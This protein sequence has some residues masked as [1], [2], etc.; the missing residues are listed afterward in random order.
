MHALPGEVLIVLPT[1]NEAKNLGRLV[2]ELRRLQPEADLLVIDDGSPDGTGRVADELAADHP[3]LQVVHR[4]GKLGLGSAHVLGMDRAVEGNYRVLVTMDC[5]FTHRPEDVEKLLARLRAGGVDL[6]IG[7]RYAHRAGI[8]SWPLWRKAITR[9]A[10]LLT[11][12]LLD[13]RF[14]ATNAFRAFDAGALRRV[15]Y[16]DVRGDGYS[17]MFEMVYAC[18]TSGLRIEEVPV[19]MPIRQAGQ[20]KI[21]RKEIVKAVV[22]LGRLAYARNAG[23]SRQG[24]AR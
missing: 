8:E 16:R 6:V 24:A 19:I 12:Q 9:T 20:S 3:C 4:P 18:I 21:S 1:Y 10:H 17:F 23:K 2:S 13:I 14:D 22:A 15:A 5:D 11:T 7:T